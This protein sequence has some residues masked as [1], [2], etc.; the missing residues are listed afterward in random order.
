LATASPFD[1]A[2]RGVLDRLHAAATELARHD[3][4]PELC[5]RAVELALSLTGSDEGVV[6]LG[7]L[8]GGD[9]RLFSRSEDR[10]RRMTDAGAAELLAA[11]GVGGS[12]TRPTSYDRNACLG[13]EL[14]TAGDV[15]GAIAVARAT[16]YSDSDRQAFAI[17]ASQIAH[18]LDA[19]LVRDQQHGLESALRGFRAQADRD[20]ENRSRTAERL[21][22]AERVE[23]AHE[24][25]V[26]V[27]LAVSSHAVAGQSLRDF[28]RRLARTVGELVGAGKVLFWRLDDDHMLGPAGGFGI[29]SAFMGRLVPLRCEPGGDDL[30]SRV[31]YQDL[32]FRASNKDQTGEFAYV[33]EGLGVSSAISVPWRA[34][35]ERLGLVAAYDST[36]QGGFSREDAWVLHTAGLASGQVTRLWHAQE[37]LRK[38]VD[39]LTKVDSA[40]QLLLKNMTTVVEKE[41]KRFVTELHDDALQKLTAAELHVARLTAGIPLDAE[42]LA[43]L[44]GLLE[45]ETSLRR[46]VFDVRPPALESPDGLAQSIRDRVAMLSG[47]SI[48]TQVEI[49]LPEDLSLDVKTMV[50]RQVAEA[51]GNVERHSQATRV[52]VLL[53]VADAGVHGVVEDN[54]QGF[55]V[56]ERSN[57][58]G[59]LGL[60]AL[61]ERALMAGGWYKIESQPGFG[62]HIEFW[63]PLGQ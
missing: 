41:R 46:L 34:G 40:R 12:R 32:I 55:V 16:D 1:A 23:R 47:S 14:R 9:R 3:G 36:R 6:A 53:R 49:E 5:D 31:V 13:A 26:E 4:V 44:H 51:I 63:I 52:K 20:E 28:Y 39:R 19:A 8:D 15:F 38:S 7:T 25:A 2:L 56:A 35:E 54:G 45:T 27:L 60:L 62:S 57:L 48:S 59:H 61:R 37:D 21:R 17:F 30:A 22:S 24:L 33:L 11:A 18:A 29:D 43:S 10:S 42:A 58:P 50:F